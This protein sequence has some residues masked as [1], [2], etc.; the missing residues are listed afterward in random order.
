MTTFEPKLLDIADMDLLVDALAS[1]NLL[2]YGEI[3]GIQEN[4]HV[5]YTLVHKLGIQ[6]LAVEASPT[7][8]TFIERIVEGT[9][10]FLTVDMELF[11]SSIVSIEVATTL[12]TL[13][14]EGTLQEVMYI[15]TYFDT[16]DPDNMDDNNSPQVREQTLADNIL[17]LDST[18]RTLCIMG[19]WHTQS[20]PVTLNDSSAEHLSALWRIRQTQ[21]VTPFC[22]VVYKKGQLHNDGRLIDLPLN[23]KLPDYYLLK[24]ASSIDFELTVPVATSTILPEIDTVQS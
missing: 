2:I 24:K 5:I 17:A 20:Q 15:D 10:D 23:P 16:V 19:Q 1:T 11:D 7:I 6:H 8:K 12:A 3:H 21:P 13:L 22:H 9:Y 4:A 14:K 18:K